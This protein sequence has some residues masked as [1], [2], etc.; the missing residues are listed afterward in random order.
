MSNDTATLRKA[1]DLTKNDPIDA[2]FIDGDHSYEGILADWLLYHPLVK[3]GGIVGFHDAL[4]QGEQ[5]GVAKFLD[6]LSKGKIDGTPRELQMI[7]HSKK[8]GIA[9]YKKD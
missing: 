3:K 7:V 5:Y 4:L 9:Y 6:N 2:L 1:H 8:T